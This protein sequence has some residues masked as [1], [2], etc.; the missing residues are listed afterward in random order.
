MWSVVG[1]S[2]SLKRTVHADNDAPVSRAAEGGTAP[3]VD[4]SHKL[5]MGIAAA[6]LNPQA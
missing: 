3:R 5:N 6:G 4:K 2:A 1:M